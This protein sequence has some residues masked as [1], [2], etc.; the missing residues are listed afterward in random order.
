M[1]SIATYTWIPLSSSVEALIVRMALTLAFLCLA[2]VISIIIIDLALYLVRMLMVNSTETYVAIKR[3]LSTPTIAQLQEK[4]QH[5]KMEQRR[6]HSEGATFL[7]HDDEDDDSDGADEPEEPVTPAAYEEDHDSDNLDEDDHYLITPATL[8][9]QHRKF[10]R[11]KTISSST[12]TRN[13]QVSMVTKKSPSS[14]HLALRRSRAS[15]SATSLTKMMSGGHSS[16]GATASG[17]DL[18]IR[19]SVNTCLD[20]RAAAAAAAGGVTKTTGARLFLGS[21]P[22]INLLVS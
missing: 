11:P 5:L 20:A 16:T 12:L 19:A 15:S 14:S 9:Q 3:R 13:T 22:P 18:N 1:I 8:K 21:N 2:P 17:V 10:L 6:P 7:L 4:Q